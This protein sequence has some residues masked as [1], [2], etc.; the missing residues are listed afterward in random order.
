MKGAVP[1]FKSFWVES[2]LLEE[3]QEKTEALSGERTNNGCRTNAAA[4]E[5]GPSGRVPYISG[6]SDQ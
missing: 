6:R 2:R 5:M 1:R 4:Q 3:P